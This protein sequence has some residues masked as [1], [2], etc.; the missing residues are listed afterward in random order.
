MTAASPVTLPTVP[1]AV[2]QI[3]LVAKDLA[4]AV[5]FYRDVVGLPFL[6]EYPGLAFFMCGTVRL[7]LSAPESAEFDHPSSVIYLSVGDIAG[8]HARMLAAGG[9]FVDAPHVVH[10]TDVYEL[11]M[12]F[13]HDPDRNPIALMQEKPLPR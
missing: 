7:M 10:R 5:A 13:L 3:S 4:R 12:T 2:G 9:S 8:A 6:F 11:W 1:H